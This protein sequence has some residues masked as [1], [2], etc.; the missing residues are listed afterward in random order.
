MIIM[1]MMIMMIINSPMS[2]TLLP[3]C[4]FLKPSNSRRIE[5]MRFHFY[6]IQ[7][8]RTAVRLWRNGIFP[9]EDDMMRL[10]VYTLD[11]RVPVLMPVNGRKMEEMVIMIEGR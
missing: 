8:A 2:N 3:L 5:T 9:Y 4:P 11:H 6:L 7:L 1:M 10:I